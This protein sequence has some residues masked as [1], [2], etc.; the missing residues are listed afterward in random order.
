[1]VLGTGMQGAPDMR[2]IDAFLTGQTSERFPQSRT[3]D[4]HN[5]GACCPVREAN[6][7]RAHPFPSPA[8]GH[9]RRLA[10]Y[11]TENIRAGTSLEDYVYATQFVQAE[12]V[13]SAFSSWRRKFRGGVEGADCAGALVWQLNDV[14]C[15]NAV[16]LSDF[17]DDSLRSGPA[18]AGRSSITTCA[19]NLLCVDARLKRQGVY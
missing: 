11:I 14:V 15:P 19:Q 18:R 3:M 4:A 5:K 13:S 17:S 16:S 7:C 10:T 1:M 2:T 12:A 6:S 9:E 8:V